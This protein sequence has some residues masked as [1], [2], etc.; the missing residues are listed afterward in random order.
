VKFS[1]FSNHFLIL[2]TAVIFL[3]ANFSAFFSQ[4]ASAE[5]LSC[6]GES[7]E[8][9]PSA[10]IPFVDLSFSFGGS[11]LNTK[12]SSGSLAKKKHGWF[13]IDTACNAS[14][15]DKSLA[16]TSR[17]GVRPNPTEFDFFQNLQSPEF[18]WNDYSG[19]H[20]PFKQSGVVGTDLLSQYVYAI[21]LA[22]RKIFQSSF[23][24][25]CSPAQ[26]M[27]NRFLPLSTAGYFSNDPEAKKL[28]SIQ[29]VR[30]RQ[31]NAENLT[32]PNG[33]VV[34]IKLAQTSGVAMIDSG[35]DDRNYPFSVNINLAM[36]NEVNKN[37]VNRKE[38][39]L[40]RAS[41][42]PV[43][44]LETC[45]KGAAVTTTAYR[46]RHGETF[47]LVS[48]TGESVRTYTNAIF[49][50]KSV[51][52]QALE[53]GGIATWETPAA[54]IGASFLKDFGAIVFN[55]KTQTVWIQKK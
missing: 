45:I 15:L 26:L 9:N 30:P 33:P 54:Q 20:L 42:I 47:A 6:L 7:V 37:E 41:E 31:K 10:N 25:T 52:A 13:L 1:R 29:H 27:E 19:F 32:V 55:A 53:C 50:L 28:F 24:D 40:I 34:S 18:S 22:V 8:L 36:L 2:I 23:T 4:A 3:S 17:H 21:D 35:F 51:T 38:S 48:T 39:I 11:R 43:T 44:T 16:P 46:L 14:Y 49:F 12:N 5:N